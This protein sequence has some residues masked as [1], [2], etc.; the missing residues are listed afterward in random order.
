MNTRV[1]R[2]V[3]V[4]AMGSVPIATGSTYIHDYFKVWPAPT[5]QLPRNGAITLEASGGCAPPIVELGH[6]QPYLWGPSGK[7]PLWIEQVVVSPA[8]APWATQVVLRPARRLD[9][10][11][12]YELRF[13]G[14]ERYTD[15][16]SWRTGYEEDRL[17]PEVCA[18]DARVSLDER[19]GDVTG[20]VALGD[21]GERAPTQALVALQAK[22]V[23]DGERPL[24][25][26][27]PIEGGQIQ[28]DSTGGYCSGRHWLEAGRCYRMWITVEDLA[29]N[30]AAVTPETTLQVPSLRPATVIRSEVVGGDAWIET[31][32]DPVYPA[33]AKKAGVSG[34][35][36]LQATLRPDGSVE[37][38]RIERGI[39]LFDAASVDALKRWRFAPA[40]GSR[41]V[42]V[43]MTFV[44]NRPE[45]VCAQS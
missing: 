23:R 20:G 37:E 21:L 30:R 34:T 22:D 8:T 24:R 12:R 27:A 18:A 36:V 28:L 4:I 40:T 15:P 1:M 10:G 35:V 45:L 39:P 32:V 17:S 11:A 16:P 31:K 42:T 29:G 19:T 3:M 26:L 41:V 44:I 7:V 14:I 33:I 43:T 6:R 38:A 2:G 9:A 5:V 13:R 25:F